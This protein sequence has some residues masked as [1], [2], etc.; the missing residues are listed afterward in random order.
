MNINKSKETFTELE[1]SVKDVE[2][3]ILFRYQTVK[4]VVKST[5]IN[6]VPIGNDNIS[7]QY[8]WESILP[9]MNQMKGKY[10]EYYQW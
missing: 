5:L 2:L 3:E 10:R 6:N 4:S 1:T 7:K 8:T 9:G